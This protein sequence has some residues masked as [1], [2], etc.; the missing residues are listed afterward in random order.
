MSLPPVILE[1]PRIFLTEMLPA[2]AE[3]AFE[4]N[5]DPLVVRYTGDG[6]FESIEAAR[7]FLTAYPDYRT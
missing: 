6:P 7:A 3:Q 2:D 1:T 4:L 5:A